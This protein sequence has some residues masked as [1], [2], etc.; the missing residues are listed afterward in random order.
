M[1][2]SRESIGDPCESGGVMWEQDLEIGA[3][4]REDTQAEG[5]EV[6]CNARRGVGDGDGGDM[7]ACSGRG[8]EDL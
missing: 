4:R 6:R 2:C 3:M 7:G 8:A 5:V 1:Q